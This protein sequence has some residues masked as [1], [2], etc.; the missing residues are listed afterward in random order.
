MNNKCKTIYRTI[1]STQYVT[2]DKH[3]VNDPKLSLGAKGLLLYLLSKPDSF[4][5]NTTEISKHCRNGRDSILSLSKELMQHGYLIKMTKR[6]YDGTYDYS[7]W[8]VLEIPDFVNKLNLKQYDDVT[9]CPMYGSEPFTDNPSTDNPVTGYPKS[10]K[11]TTE[12][13]TLLNNHDNKND[14]NK[15][16]TNQST[17]PITPLSPIEQFL[18]KFKIELPIDYDSID[19]IELENSINY[20]KAHRS[21]V[22]NPVAYLSK[23]LVDCPRLENYIIEEKK[24]MQDKKNEQQIMNQKIDEFKFESKEE[25]QYYMAKFRERRSQFVI[26][27]TK[28]EI[29]PPES[30][31]FLK[32]LAI[33]DGSYQKTIC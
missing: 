12:K 28:P 23:M 14:N 9:D 1:K 11:P 32:Y 24:S 27:F 30:L 18:A 13:T 26:Y 4:Q 29:L 8:Y 7:V 10:K 17:I 20:F 15:K 25:M 3:F 22:T 19:K 33:E 5:H 2:V 21:E 6:C 31:R 16:E